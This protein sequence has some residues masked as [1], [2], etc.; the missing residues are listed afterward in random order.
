MIQKSNFEEP[1]S[2]KMRALCLLIVPFAAAQQKGTLQVRGIDDSVVH[3]LLSIVSCHAD[4][5]INVPG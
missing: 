2:A 5:F 3:E 1:F 4:E